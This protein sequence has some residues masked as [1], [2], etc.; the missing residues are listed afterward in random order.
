MPTITGYCI[1]YLC[2]ALTASALAKGLKSCISLEI[3]YHLHERVETCMILNIAFTSI[4]IT[5]RWNIDSFHLSRNIKLWAV[6]KGEGIA[7]SNLKSAHL[8]L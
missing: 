7:R 3:F 1:I 4:I 8:V 5:R 6:I 2:F